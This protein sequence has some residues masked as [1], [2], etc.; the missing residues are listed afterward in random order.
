MF[1]INLWLYKW[2]SFK[3]VSIKNMYKR[4]IIYNPFPLIK[5]SNSIIYRPFYSLSIHV[6]RLYHWKSYFTYSYSWLP[7]LDFAY[8]DISLIMNILIN[9]RNNFKIRQVQLFNNIINLSESMKQY[10][11]VP[12]TNEL[13]NRDS[14]VKRKRMITSMACVFPLLINQLS[15]ILKNEL[16]AW[17]ILISKHR[18]KSPFSVGKFNWS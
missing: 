8:F 12:T 13:Q 9:V 2:K 4:Y 16:L 7:G 6:F 18:W 3:I 5:R 17:K 11:S 14:K 10:I 15:M 1:A